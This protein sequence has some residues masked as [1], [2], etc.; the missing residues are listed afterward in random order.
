MLARECVILSLYACMPVNIVHF[1]YICKP[2]QL[3]KVIYLLLLACLKSRSSTLWPAVQ[4]YIVTRLI[5]YQQFIYLS[6][7]CLHC[8]LLR[9]H[10][11]YTTVHN[12]S[13]PIAHLPSYSPVSDRLV[14]IQTH[15]YTV[16]AEFCGSVNVI[17]V[18]FVLNKNEFK[19]WLGCSNTAATYIQKFG[20]DLELKRLDSTWTPPNRLSR[21]NGDD[22]E[23][24]ASIF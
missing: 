5:T 19:S 17:I 3:S 2:V 24:N 6:A 12:V 11:R 18:M 15:N 13:R 9:S 14:T 22:S 8:Q 21:P 1:V 16:S 10:T 20:G 7:I 4:Q 23:V